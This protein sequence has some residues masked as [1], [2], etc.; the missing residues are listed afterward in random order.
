[1]IA[2]VQGIGVRVQ[3][4]GFRRPEQSLSGGGERGVMGGSR[5]VQAHLY[6]LRERICV[7]LITSDRRLEASREG[8][9]GR[10]CG[11]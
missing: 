2:W 9:K 6:Q 1:M 11:T 5:L 10:I 8:S 7:E 3:G 4:R